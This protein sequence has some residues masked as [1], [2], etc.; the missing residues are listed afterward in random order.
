MYA[1]TI[2]HALET[3]N[4]LHKS[5]IIII[6]TGVNNLKSQSPEYVASQY[7]TL[8]QEASRKADH[9]V[10]SLPIPSFTKPWNDKINQF[11][12]L[13]ENGVRDSP[14]ITVCNNKTLIIMTTQLQGTLRMMYIRT[15]REQEF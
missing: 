12:Q 11:K 3:V 6:H 7:R 1:P 8:L 2:E 13:V 14:V 15:K 4:K 9:I 5:E 10:L